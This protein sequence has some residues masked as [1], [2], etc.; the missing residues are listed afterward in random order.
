MKTFQYIDVMNKLQI[1]QSLVIMTLILKSTFSLDIFSS[2]TDINMLLIIFVD[3][4]WL[5]E[6]MLSRRWKLCTIDFSAYIT[7]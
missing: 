6:K 1:L 5:L 4:L 3:W 7:F 2:L